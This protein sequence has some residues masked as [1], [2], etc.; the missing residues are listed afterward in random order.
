M[1]LPV[2]RQVIIRLTS[3]D[4]IHS[5]WVPEFRVKQDALPGKALVKELRVTPN[6]V[7][8]YKVRCAEL[9]GTKHAYMES[10]VVV[11]ST[12]DFTAWMDKE[13]A[14]LNNPVERGKKAAITCAGCH[15]VDGTLGV[16]PAGV[17]L[18][19]RAAGGGGVAAWVSRTASSASTAASSIAPRSA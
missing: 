9:C 5:F 10:P 4:V 16:G 18:A 17:P 1:Y 13:V 3:E 15:S 8:E 2:D 12:S 19:A 6:R 7:G 14:L 11:L